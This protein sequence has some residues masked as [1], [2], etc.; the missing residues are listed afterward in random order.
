MKAKLQNYHNSVWKGKQDSNNEYYGLKST[1]ARL[2]KDFTE[3]GS[4]AS[5]GTKKR[6]LNKEKEAERILAKPKIT[7]SVYETLDKKEEYDRKFK[8]AEKSKIA[9]E[10]RQNA[11][12]EKRDKIGNFQ[13]KNFLQTQN[14]ITSTYGDRELLNPNLL[15]KHQELRRIKSEF[16]NE[17]LELQKRKSSQ[18]G[19]LEKIKGLSFKSKSTYPHFVPTKEDIMVEKKEARDLLFTKSK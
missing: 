1:A 9:T 19:D 4:Q 13:D 5:A 7:P 18:I 11:E 14:S 17:K 10:K 8:Q 2:G 6:K 3:S 12:M 16:A 15:N